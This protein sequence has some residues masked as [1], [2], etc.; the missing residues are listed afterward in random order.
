VK[1][2]LKRRGEK[3]GAQRNENERDRSRDVMEI[4]H[5]NESILENLEEARMVSTS[6][7]YYFVS[8]AWKT[9]DND[10]SIFP[11]HRSNINACRIACNYS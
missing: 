5:K 3:G 1:R 4:P 8:M 2:A 6:Y 11:V 7:F 10:V 9:T